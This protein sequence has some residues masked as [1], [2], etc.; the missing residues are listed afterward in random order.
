[1]PENKLLV[2]LYTEVCGQVTENGDLNVTAIKTVLDL[3]QVPNQL[4][5][6]NQLLECNRICRAIHKEKEKKGI[7]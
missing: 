7:K 5:M 2:K 4:K 3:Y 1:M 6:L